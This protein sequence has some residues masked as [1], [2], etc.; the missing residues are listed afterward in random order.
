MTNQLT[1]ETDLTCDRCGHPLDAH[2]GINLPCPESNGPPK[3]RVT[4]GACRGP[5][6]GSPFK[7]Q[8]KKGDKVRWNSPAGTGGGWVVLGLDEKDGV[9]FPSYHVRNSVTG[10]RGSAMQNNLELEQ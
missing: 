8:F 4:G 5:G 3:R 9:L 1:K 7:A 10:I 2:V 6:G